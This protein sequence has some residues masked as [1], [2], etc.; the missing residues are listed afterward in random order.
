MRARRKT[1]TEG[2]AGGRRL[3]RFPPPGPR[4]PRR[5]SLAGAVIALLAFAGSLAATVAP[6]A[7][8]TASFP[9]LV[10]LMLIRG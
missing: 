9:L 8:E 2:P 7:G 4:S 6:A 3:A 10:L 1:A 5:R